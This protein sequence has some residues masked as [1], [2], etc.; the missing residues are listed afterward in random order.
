VWAIDS[1]ETLNFENLLYVVLRDP[2][3][4]TFLHIGAHDGKSFSDPLY[5]FVTTNPTRVAGVLVEPVGDTFKRLERNLGGIPSLQLLNAAIHP[6]E[7]T[8]TI[9]RFAGNT[10]RSGRYETGLSSVDV[11]RL[12]RH[13][14]DSANL[15]IE[16]EE[17]P[18]ISLMECARLL[19]GFG[20]SAPHVICID[21]EGLDFDL[22]RSID[23]EAIAPLIIR[24]EH[25]LCDAQPGHSVDDYLELC[26]WLNSMGFQVFTE[27]NDAVAVSA[28]LI[29]MIVRPYR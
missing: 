24:F 10:R 25:N 6:T 27:H 14:A 13:A 17:V 20:S 8:V 16:H 26:R 9:H 5:S 21:T 2:E 4:V 11:D 12:E 7:K 19:P 15:E 29:P 23:F 22:V 18:A 3:V 28:R 1:S